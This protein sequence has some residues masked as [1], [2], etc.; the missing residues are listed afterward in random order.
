MENASL[1]VICQLLSKR[2]FDEE[3][4]TTF[5]RNKIDGAA[6]IELTPEDLKELHITAL[7]D[8]K[9]ICKVITECK[10]GLP[11]DIMEGLSSNSN[12]DFGPEDISSRDNLVC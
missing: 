4:L 12:N 1:S 3:V 6:F 7:G 10:N 2:G 9:K 8:R 11:T 5:R